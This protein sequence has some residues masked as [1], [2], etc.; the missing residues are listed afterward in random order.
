MKIATIPPT[1]LLRKVP[2]DGYHLILAKQV[3]TIPEYRDFYSERLD[4]G[5]YVILDN[6]ASEEGKS[7]ALDQLLQAARY[8]LSGCQ[9]EQTAAERLELVLPDV[10]EDGMGTLAQSLMA[11]QPI[12]AML[13]H[14]PLMFVPH[15]KTTAEVRQCASLAAQLIGRDL[16]CIGIGRRT[17]T[18]YFNQVRE[19]PDTL[20]HTMAVVHCITDVTDVFKTHPLHLLGLLL[21]LSLYDQA[22]GWLHRIRGLDSAKFVTF[23]LAQRSLDE[24]G[25]S[26]PRHPRYFSTA[27]PWT[28]EIERCFLDNVSRGLNAFEMGAGR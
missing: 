19:F 6:N 21:P 22:I 16:S 15:G 2:H 27:F 28:A 1:S 17:F 13:P 11:V 3:F 10:P 14:C 7:I 8:L 9:D 5:D 4:A 23:A 12:R 25:V 18:P 26:L 20:T 24:L